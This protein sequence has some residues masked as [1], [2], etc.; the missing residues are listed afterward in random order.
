MKLRDKNIVLSLGIIILI[1][2]TYFFA[3]KKTVDLSHS[4]DELLMN[5]SRTDE[6]AITKIKL[7]KRRDSL[8]NI[9][10]GFKNSSV[11][12]Q[13]KLLVKLDEYAKENGVKIISINEPFKF[14]IND[15]VVNYFR[16]SLQGNYASMAKTLHK[17]ETGS[18]FGEIISLSLLKKQDRRKRKIYLEAEAIL[19]TTL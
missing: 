15:V 4:Y 12:L 5:K 9:L 2:I 17:I 16:F 13:N 10:G 8:Q 18:N 1:L 19:K 7:E 6:Y 3:I 14:K 11:Y